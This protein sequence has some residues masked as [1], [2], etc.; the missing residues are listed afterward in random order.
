[1]RKTFT[2]MLIMSA[3][4][5]FVA[6]AVPVFTLQVYDRVIF[7]AGRSALSWQAGRSG[8]RAVWI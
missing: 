3:F 6:L 4:V 1:M 5:N 8:S 2:E 7:K